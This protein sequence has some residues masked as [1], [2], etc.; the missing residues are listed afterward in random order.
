MRKAITTLGIIGFLFAPVKWALHI[1]HEIAD[2]IGT[3]ALIIEMK[4]KGKA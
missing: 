4:L 1:T 2:E 3:R